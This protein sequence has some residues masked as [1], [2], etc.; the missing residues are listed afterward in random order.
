MTAVAANPGMDR[1]ETARWAVCFAA[2][3]AA[4]AVAALS[5]F[6]SPQASD[7][8]AGAPVVLLEL[9]EA[10]ASAATPPSD[11]TPGPPEAESEPTPPK[12]QETKPPEQEAEVALPLP[13][14]PK[15]KPP[16]EE[17]PPTAM[18][19]VAM[20]AA[21][22]P[23]TPGAAVVTS[24]AV[25]RWESLL[26]AHIE[27]F[28]RYPAE[29]R[30]RDERGTRRSPLP[31]IAMAGCVQAASCKAPAPRRWMPRPS[32]C[33]TGRS[34]CRGLQ[35]RFQVASCRS[36]CR[37]DLAS[38]EPGKPVGRIL[39]PDRQHCAARRKCRA[40]LLLS[41]SF[42]S[43]VAGGDATAQRSRTTDRGGAGLTPSS[44]PG[45]A[46]RRP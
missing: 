4:H 32:R 37:C 28:K 2:V 9:P 22:A 13:E 16:T 27:R 44:R 33:S 43:A 26:T 15:P 19:S 30:A 36:S 7:F 11:L 23:P 6:S 25:K 5:L 41:S 45:L 29:A 12:E 42:A 10:P 14:P 34:R 21:P 35:R 17:R 18:P 20:P 31:S 8:D 38:S 40:P 46:R 24:A 39:R 3:V 1:A